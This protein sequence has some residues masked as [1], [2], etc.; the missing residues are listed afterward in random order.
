MAAS[1]P[2]TNVDKAE[3]LAFVTEAFHALGLTAEDAAIFAGALVF[4]EL[5]FHPGQGQGVAR[6]RRYHERIGKGEVNPRAGWS[7]GAAML[8]GL[9]PT[10]PSR[11]PQ[12]A[13]SGPAL[14]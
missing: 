13:I 7:V 10:A 12:G 11:P 1:I 8:Q 9:V 6:L 2:M 5:R 4:S 14:V 3:L